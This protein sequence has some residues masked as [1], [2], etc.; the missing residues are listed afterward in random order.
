MLKMELYAKIHENHLVDKIRGYILLKK[1]MVG[2]KIEARSNGESII[3]QPG[4]QLGPSL[5]IKTCPILKYE[6][7][8]YKNSNSSENPL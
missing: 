7:L 3:E 8:I 5:S 4:T 1:K 2:N 6:T